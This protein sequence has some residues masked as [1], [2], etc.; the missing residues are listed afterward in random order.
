MVEIN[1]REEIK[2]KTLISGVGNGN[3]IDDDDDDDDDNEN[4]HD[5]DKEGDLFWLRECDRNKLLL[6]TTGALAL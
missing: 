1:V 6:C 5:D 4:K 3:N 2:R